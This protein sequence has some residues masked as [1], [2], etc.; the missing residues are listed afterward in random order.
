MKH[1]RNL[2]GACLSGALLAACATHSSPGVVPSFNGLHN[3][4]GSQSQT[5]NYTG[6]SQTFKVPA[7]VTEVTVVASGASGG[8]WND[9]GAL[10]GL[11]QATISVTPGRLLAI[12]V[13][14]Q[15][16]EHLRGG[17]NGGGKI[18]GDLSASSGGGA[19]DVRQGGI[20]RKHRV[21]V[22]GG[23]GGQGGCGCAGTSGG[24]GGGDVGGSGSSA[25][26][27]GG[28]DG[29][30]GGTQ[31]SGGAGGHA[32]CN[33]G[34]GRKGRFFFGGRGG[35]T[36]CGWGGGGGGGGYYGGGGGGGGAKGTYYQF[37]NGGGGGGG[38]SFVESSATNVTNTQGGAALGNGSIVIFWY[39]KI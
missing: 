34:D 16:A 11:V 5:F 17:Y 33:L 25:G 31:T 4:S 13:G 9:S 39:A 32:N 24:E 38:S 35:A 28:G 8:P 15:G 27:G 21:I 12:F 1:L 2:V 18:W 22:A 14:G 20:S 26:S 29:G 19:S 7:G 10:G 3:N 6:G 30:T 23:G 36:W 37:N